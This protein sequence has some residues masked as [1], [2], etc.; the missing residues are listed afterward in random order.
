MTDLQF[1]WIKS[2]IFIKYR[3]VYKV[4]VHYAASYKHCNSYMLTF[5]RWVHLNIYHRCFYSHCGLKA[6]WRQKDFCIC[7]LTRLTGSVHE[8]EHNFFSSH[9]VMAVVFSLVSCLVCLGYY[10]KWFLPALYFFGQEKSTPL[11]IKVQTVKDVRDICESHNVLCGRFPKA[12]PCP[13]HISY[14]PK[15]LLYCNYRHFQ[16]YLLTDIFL[17]I[18]G[19]FVFTKAFIIKIPCVYGN[20]V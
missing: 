13:C 5:W 8:T 1:L 17:S 11:W 7:V 10:Y 2:S 12:I 14:Y 16:P 4:R 3:G 19:C 20:L 6:S 18:C 9:S 15:M